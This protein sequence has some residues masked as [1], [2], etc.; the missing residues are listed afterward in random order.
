MYAKDKDIDQISLNRSRALYFHCD[1]CATNATCHPK[2]VRKLR[3]PASMAA[4]MSD[5]QQSVHVHPAPSQIQAACWGLVLS[6]SSTP[7]GSTT[8]TSTR[9]RGNAAVDRD[10]TCGSY[11]DVILRAPTGSGKT[12]AFLVPIVAR[13]LAM[14]APTLQA[15]PTALPS[16][17]RSARELAK[18]A[19]MTA[20]QQGCSDVEA[21]EIARAAYISG[22]KNYTSG[23]GT[24]VSECTTAAGVEASAT[25][26]GAA[27]GKT[28]LASSVESSST[29]SN[30][31]ANETL[32][33]AFPQHLVLAPTREL[34][35][36]T[37][38]VLS[39]LLTRLGTLVPV[40]SKCVV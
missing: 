38:V 14:M 16:T 25:A 30:D 15:K 39:S 6:D 18:V 13:A 23:D 28:S 7:H 40:H 19:F 8:A 26:R 21:Q 37:G 17:A 29:V 20:K 2:Q 36:Q 4:M 31:N 27:H 11:V 10:T 22:K 33:T 34:C 35:Q 9:D 32:T 24:V 5:V 3:N 12:L 1:L